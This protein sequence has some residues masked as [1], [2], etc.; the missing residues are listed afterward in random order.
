VRHWVGSVAAGLIG[1]GRESYDTPA[2]SLLVTDL[3]EEQFRLLPAMTRDVTPVLTDTRAWRDT[4]G[5]LFG[6]VHGDPRNPRVP[7]LIAQLS[8]GLD[9][10]FLVGG[11]SSSG[12]DQELAQVA[13]E[14]CENGLSGVLFAADV[15]VITGLTQGCSVIGHRHEITDGEGHVVARLDGRPALDVLREE[16]GGSLPRG[17]GQVF[18][19]L[20]VPGS[21]TGDYLVRN[22]L[23]IDPDRGLLAIGDR[24]HP[25][26]QLQFARRDALT[27]RADLL[28]MLRG[29][30]AR[31]GGRPR[32]ALYFSCQGRG[33]Q[34]FGPDSAELA[35][36][37]GE[38][39]EDLP[40]AGFYASGEISN[41][42]LYG[43]TG[44]LTVFL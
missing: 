41:H 24:F 11:L 15:P 18:A 3:A 32:G 40:L 17:G 22:L 38:L 20:P 37:A 36:I 13:G 43:Y 6:V 34:L 14:R 12:A 16:L 10:G 29:I 35:L 27:A 7:H 39:G 21:D 28:R 31:L 33:R 25:G 8:Q 19:A 30:R 26:M 9:G 44:V 42:R 2:L 5:G 23:G 4:H 1:S